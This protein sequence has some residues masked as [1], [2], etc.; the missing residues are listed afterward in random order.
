MSGHPEKTKWIDRWW[1]LLL[2][3]FASSGIATFIFFH[4]V[5]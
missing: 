3:L 5:H 4:P 2:I 1:P